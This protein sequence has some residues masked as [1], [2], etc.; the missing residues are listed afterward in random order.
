MRLAVAVIF[1][2]YI[3]LRYAGHAPHAGNITSH[4]KLHKSRFLSKPPIN[5]VTGEKFF[6]VNYVLMHK[7]LLSS[8]WKEYRLSSVRFYW[9]IVRFLG[10]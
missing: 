2:H 7:L 5:S 8:N 3:R 1:I 4:K 10:L 6:A 9:Y